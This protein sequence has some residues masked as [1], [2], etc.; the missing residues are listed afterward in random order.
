VKVAVALPDDDGSP[1]VW[2]VVTPNGRDGRDS[3]D[4]PDGHRGRDGTRFVLDRSY[5][6]QGSV[7][8]GGSP[9]RMFRLGPAGRRVAACLEE[10]SALPDGHEEL[11]DRFVQAGVVHPCPAAPP[12]SGA[13]DVTVVR[14]AFGAPP[15]PAG[16]G[17]LVELIVDDASPEPLP[18]VPGTQAVRRALNGGPAAARNTG[19]AAAHT[20]L[21]AFVDSDVRVPVGWLE[22]LV[23][24]FA[25]DRVGLVAPRVRTEG[26]GVLAS[27]EWIR[28]PLD[29]GD[30]PAAV[31][32]G[33][34]VSYVPGAVM[35]C[36]RVALESVGGFDESLRL[37]E[38]VDL[39]WRLDAAGWRCRHEPAV[40]V[41][42]RVRSTP[43][44]WLRQRFAYA[45][46]AGPLARR[47]PG[48]LPPAR[49]GKLSAAAWL[50]VVARRPFLA[51]GCAAADA[52]LRWRRHG[53]LPAGLRAEVIARTQLAAGEQ[54][55]TGATRVWLPV[56]IAAALISRRCRPTLAAVVLGVP[57][58]AWWR[59]DGR[60]DPAR[61]VAAHLADDAAYCAGLWWGAWRA[62]ALDALLPD[63]SPATVPRR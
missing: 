17:A 22:P 51:A 10:G 37:G 43:G 33:S 56:T 1:L 25:D 4:G 15:L 42:H 58:V 62:G 26:T 24:H 55:A 11:I 12:P 60:L 54:L 20:D 59:S 34:T 45:S 53:V 47:H 2:S 21:V 23:A 57:L 5:R 36:R 40:V 38:D 19:L 13:L 32:P 48:L 49:L 39:L 8:V 28:S 18:S 52:A 30:R 31:R 50:A 14:P 6:R 46:S 16:G 44:A 27:F 41:V 9:L 35:V 7:V 61:F 3:P 29:L 63:L